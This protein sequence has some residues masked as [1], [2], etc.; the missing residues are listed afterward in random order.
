ML[1]PDSHFHHPFLLA[2][3][4]THVPWSSCDNDWNTPGKTLPNYCY[5]QTHTSTI[6]SCWH[7]STH[8]CLGLHL[9][10]YLFI[11]SYLPRSTPSVCNTVLHATMTGIHQV[12]HC[13]IIV[14]PRLT[15]PPSI[16][17][18]ILQH[19]HM[20][21]SSCDNDWNTPGKTLPNYCYTQTHTST[22]HSCWHPST[23]TCL[24]LHAT[25]TGIH[26]VRHC[27]IIVTPRLTLPPSIPAG[28]LQHTHTCLGLHATMTGIHQVRHC[29]IIITP[30]S[31]FHH[32]FSLLPPI[33]T[34][35]SLLLSPT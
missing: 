15:L 24:G 35:T 28:I 9:F 19:T 1:H 22:I 4:N 11:M 20:P 34:A 3:F 29:L 2:S 17:A 13:L 27:L 33:V 14:T 25:M 8:T 21:W 16:P 12:R 6:H 23:H 10:I 31:H 5:T 26:Q 30:D 32:P 18:G 7:P